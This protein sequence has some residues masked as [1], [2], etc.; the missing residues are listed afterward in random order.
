MGCWLVPTVKTCFR[1]KQEF[2]ATKEYF[3]GNKAKSDKLSSYCKK[4]NNSYV[5][6]W[7]KEKPKGYFDIQR[8]ARLKRIGFTPELVAEMLESQGNVCAL[9]GTSEPG[10]TRKTW[11]SDHDHET[12]K[13]RGM[14]CMSC[15]TTVGH[16][17]SKPNGWMD[18]AKKY[19]DE[20]GFFTGDS[21]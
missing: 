3:Y 6:K 19:I 16:I 4:C 17:E 7:S 13:A 2:P 14:L 5:T 12:G 21:Q 20:G 18:K 8:K 15:N 1:C 11:H 9:C 10:G